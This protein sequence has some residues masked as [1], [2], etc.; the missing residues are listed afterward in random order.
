MKAGLEARMNGFVK[1]LAREKV[2]LGEFA[3]LIEEC[4]GNRLIVDVRN[5]NGDVLLK[6][7]GTLQAYPVR[8]VKRS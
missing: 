6:D 8:S 7:I 2:T 1:Q 4:T 3:D 5:R